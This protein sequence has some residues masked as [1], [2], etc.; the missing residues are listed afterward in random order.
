MYLETMNLTFGR[1]FHQQEIRGNMNNCYATIIWFDLYGKILKNVFSFY[2]PSKNL[3]WLIQILVYYHKSKVQ[4]TKCESKPLNLILISIYKYFFLATEF[5]SWFKYTP[6]PYI[7][8]EIFIFHFG[9][10]L[11]LLYCNMCAPLSF[12]HI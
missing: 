12:A 10:L 4:I 5:F 7:I 3:K 11:L 6:F 8:T 2:M 9:S 1:S